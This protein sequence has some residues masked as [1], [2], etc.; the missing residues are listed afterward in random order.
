MNYN[1]LGKY[2]NEKMVCICN[3]NFFGQLQ[4]QR[5]TIFFHLLSSENEIRRIAVQ[6]K[7]NRF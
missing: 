5:Y 2:P 6:I 1:V 3:N 7:T 4:I